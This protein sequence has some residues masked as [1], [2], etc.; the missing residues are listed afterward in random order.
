MGP[1]LAR[2]VLGF[3]AGILCQFTKI[4][5]IVLQTTDFSDRVLDLRCICFA[6]RVG[7]LHR[8]GPSTQSVYFLN[9]PGV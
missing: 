6:E 8:A 7:P 2:G 4:P 5:L 3:G 1:F 9:G